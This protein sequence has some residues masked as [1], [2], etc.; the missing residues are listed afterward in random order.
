LNTI[1]N[2]N[3]AIPRLRMPAGLPGFGRVRFG[4]GSY[5]GYGGYF[6]GMSIAPPAEVLPTVPPAPPPTPP[7]G[8]LLGSVPLSQ[9]TLT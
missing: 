2:S 1:R 3:T 7:V 9:I 6:G 4:W 5:G 8:P